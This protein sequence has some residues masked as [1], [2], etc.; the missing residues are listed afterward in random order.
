MKKDALD[1]NLYTLETEIES[2]SNF[3]IF[4]ASAINGN[5]IDWDKALGS[6]VDGDDSGDNFVT[7]TNT[8]AINTALDGKI[9]ISFDAY[10]YRFTVKD[11]SAP[12][13]LY[14]TGSAYNW[15][16]PAG[17]PNAW[18]ELVPVNGTKGAF[19][20]IFHFAAND[21]VKFAPQANWGNDFGFIDAISQE[22]KDLAG[23]S[24][25]GGNLKV[26]VAG[27]YLVYVSVIGDN[28]VIEFEKPNVYLMGDTSYDGW[29]AQLVEQDL[30]TVPGTADGEFVSPA[31]LKDGAVRICVNPK[32]VSA[33]D[34]WKT[35][36]TLLDGKVF[37]RENANIASNWNTDMG[38][39]YSVNAGAGQ[40]LYLTVGSTEDGLD[41]G[42]VK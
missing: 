16:N 20:G 11:N 31:F 29:N 23:L 17:D 34:W 1:E 6:S 26:G 37:W 32:A 40:K 39:E 33:G 22:S 2:T 7:W 35:E 24:D 36:F 10:N 12:T 15:G 9:K 5:D 4:P 21:Q 19:W 41:T 27:W 13:E 25:E 28:K 38:S 30:F 3:K 18:K 42:E 8:G 14:M